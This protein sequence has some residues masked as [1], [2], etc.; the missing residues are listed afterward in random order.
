[1]RAQPFNVDQYVFGIGRAGRL[2]QPDQGT[3][4]GIFAHR[5]Q[6]IQA[7]LV[8]ARQIRGQ[9]FIDFAGSQRESLCTHTFDDLDGWHDDILLSQYF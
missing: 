7:L 3:R 5:Q 4:R 2:S 1:M 8:S 9:R 6:F